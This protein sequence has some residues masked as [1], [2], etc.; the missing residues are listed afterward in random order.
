MV[1]RWP[2]E[3]SKGER[4]EDVKSASVRIKRN[5]G[6]TRNIVIKAVLLYLINWALNLGEEGEGGGG[7]KD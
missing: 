2:D 6:F 7:R 5:W 4:G 1:I 3:M